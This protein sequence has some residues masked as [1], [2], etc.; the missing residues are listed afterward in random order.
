MNAQKPI[1]LAAPAGYQPGRLSVI[2]RFANMAQGRDDIVN[3]TNG[4]ANP[5]TLNRHAYNRAG[6]THMT[7]LGQRGDLGVRAPFA[8]GVLSHTNAQSAIDAIAAALELPHNKHLQA[9]ADRLRSGYSHR[10]AIEDALSNYRG[11]VTPRLLADFARIHS[12]DTGIE[13]DPKRMLSTSGNTQAIK[14]MLEY[15]DKLGIPVAVF[16]ARPTYAGFLA[17]LAYTKN[18]RLYSVKTDGLGMKAGH[19]EHQVNQAIQDGFMP[20]FL[21]VVPDGSNP[22]GTTMSQGRRDDI[23]TVAVQTFVKSPQG[24]IILED[25]P[26]H[27]IRYG[28]GPF[29]ALMAANDPAGIVAYAFSTSKI[30]IPDERTGVF[31]VPMDL[32]LPKGGKAPL[33]K[34]MVV[35]VAAG[36]LMHSATALAK[37]T[38]QLYDKS[39]NPVGLWPRSALISPIYEANMEAMY[40]ALVAGLGIY[41]DLI[42]LG[43]KPKHGFTLN[44]RF[45]GLKEKTGMDSKQLSQWLFDEFKVLPIPASGFYPADA[46]E[47]SGLDEIRLAFS[48]MTPE[49]IAHGIEQLIRGIKQLYR[50]D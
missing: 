35:S 40:D 28:D 6:N 8:T 41:D 9:L 42:E 16:C 21:Y 37:F 2:R 27:F 36:T 15:Y 13:L 32:H 26:Y 10:A 44:I 46:P 19:L 49:E 3:F 20:G 5:A 24:L 7:R 38:G 29:P 4:K 47:G 39:G 22:K 48:F 23:Y 50:L 30:G 34:E 25:V 12:K 45:P 1:A 31:H 11:T 17:P 14:A 33:I 43:P 18:I